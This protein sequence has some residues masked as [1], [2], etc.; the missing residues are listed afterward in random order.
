LVLVGS[1]HG[2]DNGCYGGWLRW[3]LLEIFGKWI[4]CGTECF[5]FVEIIIVSGVNLIRLAAVGTTG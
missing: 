1:A 4:C 2:R 5:R 3:S